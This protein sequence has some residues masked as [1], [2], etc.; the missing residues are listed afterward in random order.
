MQTFLELTT[1]ITDYLTESKQWWS[2]FDESCFVFHKSI[3]LSKLQ[4][5]QFDLQQGE[6][7][8]QE[9]FQGK[10]KHYYSDWKFD[11]SPDEL[12]PEYYN[13]ENALKLFE[14]IGNLIEEIVIPT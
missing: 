9:I 4:V 1:P 14:E 6:T 5:L 13:K 7:Y 12:D 10:D 8:T 3:H 11:K 2:R